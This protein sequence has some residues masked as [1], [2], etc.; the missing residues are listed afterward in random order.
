MYLYLSLYIYIYI[1]THTHIYLSLSIY[2][3][4]YIYTCVCVCIYIYIYIYMRITIAKSV[5]NVKLD[6]EL[7]EDRPAHI[8]T[9]IYIYIYNT[10]ICACY[11]LQIIITPPIKT[12]STSSGQTPRSTSHL[13]YTLHGN[14]LRPLALPREFCEPG[15][16]I[17]LR[18]FAEPLRRRKLLGEKTNKTNIYLKILAREILQLSPLHPVSITRFPSQDF[19]QGLGCSGI[20]F[21][22]GSG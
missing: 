18:D 14:S 4:I 21:F 2:I 12:P 7:G 5:V 22:I 20:V 17:F 19:R 15:V 6:V 9:Y 16:D 8:H 10:C 11:M 1:Y 3:Y 13:S